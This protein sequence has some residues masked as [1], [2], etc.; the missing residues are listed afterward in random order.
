M[1]ASHTLVNVLL[2]HLKYHAEVLGLVILF[3]NLL[4]WIYQFVQSSIILIIS[5]P[6]PYL[7]T[8]QWLHLER[9]M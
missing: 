1:Q 2:D 6:V 4:Q 5:K 9:F 7:Y 3:S 8:I